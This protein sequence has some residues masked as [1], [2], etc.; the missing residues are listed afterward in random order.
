MGTLDPVLVDI[1]TQV[2]IS[3][4]KTATLLSAVLSQITE[5]PGGLAAFL[6]RFRSAGLSDLVASWLGGSVPRQISSSAL[7][8]ALSREWIESAATTAGLSISTAE[9]ALAFLLPGLIQHLTPGGLVPTRIPSDI[10]AYMRRGDPSAN[11]NQ[12]EASHG[13]A[14]R[15][16]QP[17]APSWL[18]PLLAVLALVL[19]GY[20]FWSMRH[21]TKNAGIERKHRLARIS[22]RTLKLPLKATS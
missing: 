1:A 13:T 7:E 22:R 12:R 3:T 20:C 5:W 19:L 16:K 15:A 17:G 21:A 11:A 6:E 2:G 14:R 18:W 10:L 9:S 8:T 4:P